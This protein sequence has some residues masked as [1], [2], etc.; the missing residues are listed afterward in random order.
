[1]KGANLL[2]KYENWASILEGVSI[3]FEAIEPMKYLK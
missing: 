3:P 2:Q 1:M